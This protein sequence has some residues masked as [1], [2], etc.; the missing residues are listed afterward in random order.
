[1]MGRA[2]RHELGV[3][4]AVGRYRSRWK[5]EEKLLKAEGRLPGTVVPNKEEEL[6]A[7][8]AQEQELLQIVEL[9]TDAFDVIDAGDKLRRLN[10]LREEL[11]DGQNQR[12]PASEEV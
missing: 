4:H 10:D 9:S 12:A 6:E 2:A 3:R 1:M 7:L 5:S 8:A 11:G